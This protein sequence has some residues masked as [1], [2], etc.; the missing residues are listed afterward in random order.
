G[1][2]QIQDQIMK[3]AG[4][5]VCGSYVGCSG[6]CDPSN[7]YAKTKVCISRSANYSYTYKGIAG[8]PSDG[9]SETYMSALNYLS[10]YSTSAINKD[11]GLSAIKRSCTVNPTLTYSASKFPLASEGDK[12]AT[13]TFKGVNLKFSSTT[14]SNRPIVINDGDLYV[15]DLTQKKPLTVN[16]GNV[17]GYYLQNASGADV[18][19]KAKSG[20]TPKYTVYYSTFDSTLSGST[21]LGKFTSTGYDFDSIYYMRFSTSVTGNYSVADITLREGGTLKAATTS[22]SRGILVYPSADAK[23][24]TYSSYVSIVGPSSSTGAKVYSNLHAGTNYY[25]SYKMTK[26]MSIRLSKNVSFEILD[27]YL[28]GVSP[29][30]YVQ[31]TDF[32]TGTYNAK[33]NWSTSNTAW[34]KCYGDAQI[35]VPYH[36]GDISG[37]WR[38]WKT[39]GIS[40][41]FYYAGTINSKSERTYVSYGEA[42]ESRDNRGILSDCSW[43]GSNVNMN[44]GRVEW[45]SG[46]T[47]TV[48]Y[49]V[50]CE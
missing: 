33:I 28:V 16:G 34:K 42:Q 13:M 7:S 17:S 30:S 27:G 38:S 14:T 8:V 45:K 46:D 22:W 19:L 9:N 25:D 4:S 1:N 48:R 36:A 50:F 31:A 37:C 10:S 23:T 39:N 26:G 29:N 2:Q 6:Y 41:D 43:P 15:Y 32:G 44:Y 49:N 3:P 11:T 24:S 40:S 5:Y 47:S 35:N 21:V 12:V 20:T 18:T